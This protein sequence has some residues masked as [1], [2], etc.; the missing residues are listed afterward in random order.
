MTWSTRRFWRVYRQSYQRVREERQAREALSVKSAARKGFWAT[1]TLAIFL[2]M[3]DDIRGLDDRPWPALRLALGCL[4]LAFAVWWRSEV[5][6]RR[7]LSREL[8]RQRP[9]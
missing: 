5:L 2:T 7:R 9:H 3:V 1:W 4:W 8:S 6:T